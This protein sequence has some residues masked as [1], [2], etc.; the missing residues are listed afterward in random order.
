[1]KLLAAGVGGERREG[2]GAGLA[3]A[4]RRAPGAD[5]RLVRRQRRVRHEQPIGRARL[6]AAGNALALP[7]A[8]V[9]DVGGV[10][11]GERAVAGDVGGEALGAPSNVRAAGDGLQHPRR[12]SAR[13]PRRRCRRNG[14]VRPAAGRRARR[15]ECIE[16]RSASVVALWPVGGSATATPATGW[17]PA[18]RMLPASWKSGGDVEVAVRVALGGTGVA[19]KVEVGVGCGPAAPGSASTVIDCSAQ[20]TLVR[21]TP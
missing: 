7:T 19:V 9:Q 10:E 14:A 15:R 2:D 3:G 17:P 21:R 20:V 4:A 13:R 11:R 12:V 16:C 18:V 5:R 8:C 1:M 6:G